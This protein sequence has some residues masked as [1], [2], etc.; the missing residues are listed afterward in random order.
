MGAGGP[1]VTERE[2]RRLQRISFTYGNTHIENPRI[3]REMVEQADRKL[4]SED[5]SD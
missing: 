5:Y 2:A 1:A 4:H 3:T